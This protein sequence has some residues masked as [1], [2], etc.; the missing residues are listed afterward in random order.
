MNIEELIKILLT[1]EPSDELRKNKDELFELI[2]ELKNCYKFNQ[3]NKWHPYDV[4][5]HTMHVVDNV[6]CDIKLRLTA[7]F[8]D[9]GKPLV[10][11]EDQYGIG[12]FRNHWKKSAYIFNNFGIK[13]NLD[14]NI[15]ET[16]S[17]LIYFHDVNFDK[18]TQE[19]LNTV[20][21]ILTIDEINQLF[22]IKQADLL[23]QNEEYHYLKE[24]YNKQKERVKSRYND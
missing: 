18:L 22:E 17:K 19:E 16:V 2:P 8:H 24:E 20:I 9:I 12:H 5:E 6:P 4:F 23:A 10:Y 11:T 21:G 15:V 3:N 13:N 14:S 7:L 1:Y